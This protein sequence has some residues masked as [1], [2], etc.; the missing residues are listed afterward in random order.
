M[1][2]KLHIIHEDKA[3]LVIDK[4]AG[5]LSIATEHERGL[6]ASANTAYRLMNDYVKAKHKSN[7]IWIVHRLDRDTSGVMLFA[8]SEQ[9]KLKLQENWE[10][11]AVAREYVAVVSGAVNPPQGQIKSWLKE[12]KA[13][14]VYSS[15]REGDGKLAITDYRTLA[16]SRRFTLLAVELQTG[17]KNQ[18]RVHL[19]ERG[20]PVLGDKKY[21]ESKSNPLG[22]LALHASALS[23]IHPT[24]REL[25]RFEA[26]I[27]ACF[28][29]GFPTD[30]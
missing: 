2:H 20:H 14:K 30:N 16:K 3:L 17:R 21:G 25:M 19:S 13:I 1:K 22:R 28:L 12:N 11:A 27:P 29:K 24:T 8:K 9:A 5:L 6:G 26:Q 10:E 18:I 15:G 7:K 4:P 23:V